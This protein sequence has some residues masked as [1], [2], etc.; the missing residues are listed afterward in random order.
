MRWEEVGGGRKGLK[1]REKMEESKMEWKVV[2]C[3]L[4]NNIQF[5]LL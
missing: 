5:L 3:M 4:L 2:Y 1:R